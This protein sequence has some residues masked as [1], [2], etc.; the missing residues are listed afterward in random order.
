MDKFD[1]ERTQIFLIK[2]FRYI[3][4]HYAFPDMTKEQIMDCVLEAD[5]ELTKGQAEIIAKHIIYLINDYNNL[6]GIF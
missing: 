1:I 2:C 4:N 3:E 5:F 6:N